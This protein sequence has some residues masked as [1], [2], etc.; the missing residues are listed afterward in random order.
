MPTRWKVL[1][2]VGIAALVVRPVFAQPGRGGPLQLL[3]NKDVQKELQLTD[4]QLNKARQMMGKVFGK[5]QPEFA[6]LGEIPSEQ[7]RAKVD[8]LL[9]AIGT[10]MEKEAQGIF[11]PEQ[12]K[13]FKEIEL[14]Q[15]GAEAFEDPTVRERLKLTQ[16]QQ[17]KIEAI[18]ADAAK[19]YQALKDKGNFP[20]AAEKTAAVGKAA[21]DKVIAL[22][23]EDQ[24]K[25]W[26]EL[27]GKPF[28]VKVEPRRPRRPDR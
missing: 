16:E 11:K 23:T 1:V 10:D 17:K 9:K 25:A 20:G 12:I 7:R 4:E 8:S 24:K 5:Y 13:R 21:A 22:L 26:K 15:R 18:K 14:Q 19:E 6:K 3:Q 27:T 2:L 28:E